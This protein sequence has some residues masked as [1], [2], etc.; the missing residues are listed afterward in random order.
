MPRFAVHT[1]DDA[2]EASRVALEAVQQRL[3]RALNIYGEMAHAPV[4]LAMSNAMNKALAE[5]GTFDQRT[6]EAIALAVGNQDR[7]S[8]SRSA[9]LRSTS[10]RSWTPC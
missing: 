1:L 8:Y 6:R 10:I 9:T 7:C 3:G 4:V 5:H 2:P